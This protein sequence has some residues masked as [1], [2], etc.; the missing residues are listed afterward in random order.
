MLYANLGEA[1]LTW[2]YYPLTEAPYCAYL[3]RPAT[4][5]EGTLQTIEHL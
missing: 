2:S 1:P 5:L 3:F 4:V